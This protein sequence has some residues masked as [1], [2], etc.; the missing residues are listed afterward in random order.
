MPK[1]LRSV[2]SVLVM[3]DMITSLMSGV[4]HH[5]WHVAMR[6]VDMWAGCCA[7]GVGRCIL[8]LAVFLARVCRMTRGHGIAGLLYRGSRTM[9]RMMGFRHLPLLLTGGMARLAITIGAPL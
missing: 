9:V 6:H 3:D 4:S 7:C 2:A 8:M 1:H 5:R